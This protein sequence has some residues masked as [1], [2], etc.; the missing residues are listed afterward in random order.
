[1]KASKWLMA[2][3]LLSLTGMVLAEEPPVV[4]LSG[5]QGVVDPAD[6]KK[7]DP[8]AP[9]PDDQAAD[10]QDDDGEEE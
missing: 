1:M 5:K 10:S 8:P 7:Y 3:V 4:D 9:K 2:G 6:L